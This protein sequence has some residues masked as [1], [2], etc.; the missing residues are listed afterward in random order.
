MTATLTRT[1]ETSALTRWEALE[2]DIAIAKAKA[3]DQI[4][5]Y[6]DKKDNKAARSWV[7]LLRT[8][9]GEIERAR[10]DAKAVH[11]DRGRAVDEAAKQLEASVQELIEPHQRELKALEAEDEARVRA[12]QAV[13]SRM[14]ELND[15]A[16]TAA[17]ATARLA[18]LT[19]I[20]CSKL[21]EYE[22]AGTTRLLE[23]TKHLMSV[24]ET[25]RAQE[26]AEAEL[27]SLRAEKAAREAAERE[28]QERQQALDDELKAAAAREAKALADAERALEAQRQAEQRAE[29]AEHEAKAAQEAADQAEADRQTKAA[30]EAELA[31]EAANRAEQARQQ[32]AATLKRELS[33]A[34]ARMTNSEYVADA[35]VNGTLHPAVCIDW[36]QVL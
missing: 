19:S 21:E 7:A 20:D 15:G 29:A 26:Q 5:D 28:E 18:E 35:L 23:V 30:Q 31:R 4:F 12:H 27:E 8:I 36:T 32:K 17:E 6:R 25:L 16:T 9:K 33:R 34:V 11:L 14:A 3:K 1:N 22:A 13:L 10:K 24:R 2:S